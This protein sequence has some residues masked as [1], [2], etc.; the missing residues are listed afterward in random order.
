MISQTVH[1]TG[2]MVSPLSQMYHRISVLVPVLVW[3]PEHSYTSTNKST[4]TITLELTSTSKVRV[5]EIQYRYSSIAS[6]EYEYPK[7][8]SCY[9]DIYFFRHQPR[10]QSS[11]NPAWCEATYWWLTDNSPLTIDLWILKTLSYFI[12]LPMVILPVNIPACVIL[13]IFIGPKSIFNA[14][15][16][17]GG[18]LYAL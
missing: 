9:L 12:L 7:P 17:F 10:E 11:L 3:V 4:S 15:G 6:T 14:L 5:P 18:L 2:M 16:F 13:Y 1:F 8:W